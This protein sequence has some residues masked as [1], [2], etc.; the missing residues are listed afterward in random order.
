MAELANAIAGYHRLLH[1]PKYQDLEWAEKFHVEMRRRGLCQSGRLLTPVLRPHLIS[2]EQLRRAAAVSSRLWNL[3]G[4]VEILAADS[5]QLLNRVRMLPAEK[6][7]AAIPC[8]YPRPGAASRLNA[9]VHNG[10]MTIRSFETCASV[11]LAYA[12][13]LA[14]MFLSLPIVREFARAGFKLA[15]LGAVD[16]LLRCILHA[17]T[18]FGA[19][20]LPNVAILEPNGNSIQC[21]E[22]EFIAELFRRSGI[23]AQ[24]VNLD[25]LEYTKHRLY[26]SAFPVDVLFRRIDTQDLVTRCELSHPLLTAYR[27]GAVC[28]VNG[29]RS[30]IWH[31][32]A[33]LEL[34][35]DPAIRCAFSA[36]DSALLTQVVPWTR[37][38]SARKTA[39][40]D[41]EIDLIPYLLRHRQ[42]FV[43][44]PN[45]VPGNAP[46]FTGSELSQS[47]WEGALRL[48]L[49]VPYVAQESCPIVCEEFPVYRYNELQMQKLSVAVLPHIFNGTLQGASAVLE[50]SPA[51]SAQIVGLAPVLTLQ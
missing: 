33:S 37:L 27:E 19:A 29:F 25:Q 35:T 51:S 46:V 47:A 6:M 39:Y 21:G 15:K 28:L 38:V 14:D 11:G 4:R 16:G 50:T 12:D 30:E 17:W 10:S 3:L 36:A 44:R 42:R 32:R 23:S 34:L 9:V 48:A 5:P 49:R 22:G 40:R 7:L 20:R 2:K 13:L 45:E 8:G 43:L 18:D 24:T 41:Q 31:R 1:E 26:A